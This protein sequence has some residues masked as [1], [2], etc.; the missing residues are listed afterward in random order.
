MTNVKASTK[1]GR[2]CSP[3]F[4]NG[5]WQRCTQ[6]DFEGYYQ[7]PPLRDFAS[8]FFVFDRLFFMLQ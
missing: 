2:L 5:P 1:Q 8:F 6:G 4:M 7:I 3:V